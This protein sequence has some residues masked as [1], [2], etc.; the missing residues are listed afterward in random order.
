[1]EGEAR[2]DAYRCP[3]IDGLRQRFADWIAEPGWTGRAGALV[4]ERV[5]GELTWS[6]YRNKRQKTHTIYVNEINEDEIP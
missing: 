6:T 2:D 1:M 5:R 3:V 4:G